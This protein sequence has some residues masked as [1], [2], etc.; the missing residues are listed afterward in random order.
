MSYTVSEVAR[1]TESAPISFAT[2]EALGKEFGKSTKSVI[3]KVQNLGLPY[4]K[5]EVPAKKVAPETK[6]Q[7]VTQIEANTGLELTGLSNATAAVLVALRN[8]TAPEVIEA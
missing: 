7:L 8:Y 5:K 6:A 3:S 4:I 2:A 1:I